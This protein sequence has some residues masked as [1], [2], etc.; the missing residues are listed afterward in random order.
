MNLTNFTGL[1]KHFSYIWMRK[2]VSENYLRR[3]IDM[4]MRDRQ[5]KCHHVSINLVDI[6]ML[7]DFNN[8]LCPL[9][10]EKY[11]QIKHDLF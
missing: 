9:Y 11:I 6:F 5:Y 7:L 3:V 4:I 8:T 2:Q 10:V 1:S